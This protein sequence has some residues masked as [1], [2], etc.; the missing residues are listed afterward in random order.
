MTTSALR[1]RAAKQQS[2]SAKPSSALKDTPQQA[3]APG[4]AFQVAGTNRTT[5][6]R[7]VFSGFLTGMTNLAVMQR[8]QVPAA[9]A[10][11]KTT[12]VR[13]FSET[14]S[15]VIS[16][17]AHVSGKA[18]IGADQAVNIEAMPVPAQTTR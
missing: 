9:D 7:V 4:Y 8:A 2:E 10:A 5:K 14:Q 17:S 18:L 3:A 13:Q 6:Q 1:A 11:S 15:N 16:P 12:S